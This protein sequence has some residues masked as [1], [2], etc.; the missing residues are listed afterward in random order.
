VDSHLL[1]R[2][3]LRRTGS[4]DLAIRQT[5]AG[6]AL[7]H[8]ARVSSAPLIGR[9]PLIEQLAGAVGRAQA[10]ERVTVL[11]GG[12]AGIGKT[13]LMRA[14]TADA[15]RTGAHVAWGVCPDAAGAPGYW[16]WTQA[17]TALVREVGLERARE[18]GGDDVP[19][20][21]LLCSAFGPPAG[22]RGTD[23]ERLLLLDATS[24][25]L[26]GLSRQ[27]PLVVVIDDLHWADESTLALFDFVARSPVAAPLCLI[28]AFRP[29]E[30]RPRFRDRLLSSGEFLPVTGIDAA[31]VHDLVERVRGVSVDPAVSTAIAARTRGH[32]F[33]VREL[34]L[35]AGHD[36]EVPAAVSDL[37]DRRIS[38]LSTRTRDILRA[39][40]ALG[41]TPHLDV[42]ARALE[43]RPPEVADGIREAVA[44]GVLLA[45][46]PAFSHD[47]VR[48]TVA[49][50][51]SATDRVALALRLGSA[52]EDRAARIGDVS[53]SELARQF[54]AAIAVDGADRA[55]SWT[56]AA[57]AAD[58]RA[59]A[60]DEAAGHLR[61]LRAAVADA[62]IDVDP[63]AMFEVLLAEA[64][65]LAR[66][67]GT[68]EAR[69]LLRVA[70]AVARRTEDPERIARGA[71]ALTALGSRFAVRRDDI[72]AELEQAL[73]AVRGSG[74]PLEAQV[75]AALARQLQ[76]SVATDRPRAEPLSRSALALGRAAADP[77]TLI[78]CL[79]ARH[80]VLWTPGT[81]PERADLAREIVGVAQTVGDDERRADGLVLLATALLEQG[82]PAFEPALD[83]G[84][85]LLDH[86]GQP[87]HRYLAETRR[88]CVALL[89]GDGERS[90]DL[91]ERA[92]ALGERIREPDTGN[93]R[94]SQRVELV[95]ARADADEQHAFAA[96]AVAHWTGV[97]IHAH[98]V[99]AGFSARAGDL[100]GARRHLRTV[101]DLGGWRAETSYLR[102]VFI[103]ELAQAAIAVED[104][105]LCTDLL[106]YFEPL[107]H[108]CGVNASVVAFSGSLADH[109]ARL[110]AALGHVDRAAVLLDLASTA[111]R[112]L[113]AAGWLAAL[114]SHETAQ[115]E[116]AQP[117]TACAALRRTGRGWEIVFSGRSV[118]VAHSRGLADLAH[119]IAAADRDVHVLDLVDSADRSGSGG[120]L[121]D[122][123]A[124]GA[125][126]RRIAELDGI[127]GEAAAAERAALIAEV[128]RV[129]SL[130]GRARPF[131]NTP[132][133]RARKAVSARVRDAIRRIE[134]DRPELGAHLDRSVVT[135]T[136]CRYRTEEGVS[137]DVRG[138]SV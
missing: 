122:D 70:A 56:L 109:A 30:L 50:G 133:E 67:G 16:P 117:G 59:L 73:L 54:V 25:F 39:T 7:E 28:G 6:P 20:L 93:V 89:R 92:A 15:A 8:N 129:T 47:I 29:D 76:H 114:S 105:E 21:A 33:F 51:I 9:G 135:G 85:A 134:A 69:G 78:G 63:A 65:A 123:T 17:V 112:G 100:D 34:A 128:S 10:G 115:P 81:A 107:A 35:L 3:I 66:G 49:D 26:D 13:S 19:S 41:T 108:T 32:P 79:F 18:L 97:P 99:A 119:L 57:A 131:A 77:V 43:L 110:A 83:E 87:R 27:A 125:Y 126:R 103:R 60:F 130:S 84:L 5:T 136:Y 53:P 58:C 116:T 45:E 38:R 137:W 24:R 91:I 31:A 113:G 71:L 22:E 96:E 42:L 44:A 14:A 46:G 88:A 61:R 138:Q 132:A 74:T 1:L 23:R 11:V 104:A 98:A 52:L 124:I 64:D 106:G 48:E 82:S 12:E 40:A 120:V 94:M 37:I 75:T 127:P 111:Y 90:A 118:T 36:G 2:Q 62:G 101:I 55:L 95:R 72:V 4:S 80:D 86:L 102:A 121:A 68:I